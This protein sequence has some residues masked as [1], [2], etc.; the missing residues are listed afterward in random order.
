MTKIV[1]KKGRSNLVEVYG[2]Y[3]IKDTLKTL[4]FKFNGS[5]WIKMST[6]DY[7]RD[8]VECDED[9]ELTM[10][11]NFTRFSLEKDYLSQEENDQIVAEYKAIRDLVKKYDV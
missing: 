4:G 3:E 5:T 9:D 11:K 10:S 7:S 1:V 6:S 2:G 8:I